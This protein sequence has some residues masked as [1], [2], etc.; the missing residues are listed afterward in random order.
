MLLGGYATSGLEGSLHVMSWGEVHMSYSASE[1]LMRSYA[2]R[3]KHVV[4]DAAIG[5]LSHDDTRPASA[6]G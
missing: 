2:R 3:G 4:P 5:M 6:G 1:S